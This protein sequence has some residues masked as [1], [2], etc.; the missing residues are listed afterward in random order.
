M[1]VGRTGAHLDKAM[2]QM[3]EELGTTIKAEESKARRAE[4]S[5]RAAQHSIMIVF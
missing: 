2:E 4:L 3:A 5:E 1:I